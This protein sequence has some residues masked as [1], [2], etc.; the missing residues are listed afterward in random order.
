L[1]CGVERGWTAVTRRVT[2]AARSRPVRVCRS[3]VA[4]ACTGAGLG[5]LVMGLLVDLVGGYPPAIA[6]LLAAAAVQAFAIVRITRPG[7]RWHPCRPLSPERHPVTR[8]P[9]DGGGIVSAT[10][11]GTD[12]RDDNGR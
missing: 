11:G 1:R 4:V 9:P 5:L 6:V 12:A 10:L 3:A 7:H 2:V 8:L